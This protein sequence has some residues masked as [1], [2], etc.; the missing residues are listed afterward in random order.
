MLLTSSLIILSFIVALL[1][2]LFDPR[3]IKAKLHREAKR[4]FLLQMVS[5][6][7]I[8]YRISH[9]TGTATAADYAGQRALRQFILAFSKQENIPVEV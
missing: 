7:Q 8:W 2:A 9:S 1:A 4:R 5:V 3:T 6:Y